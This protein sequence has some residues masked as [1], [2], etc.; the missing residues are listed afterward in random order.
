MFRFAFDSVEFTMAIL[1]AM[2]RVDELIRELVNS[3][4]FW[5]ESVDE[6]MRSFV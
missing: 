3:T 2:L 4:L 6:F 5:I 1:F